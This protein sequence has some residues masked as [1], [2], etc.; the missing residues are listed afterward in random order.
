MA[1]TRPVMTSGL[2]AAPLARPLIFIR[3]Q[4]KTADVLINCPKQFFLP[5]KALSPISRV[6]PARHP[7]RHGR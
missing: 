1:A 5:F 6:A 3:K 7:W 2:L 4:G